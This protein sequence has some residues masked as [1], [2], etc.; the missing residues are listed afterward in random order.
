MLRKAALQ[1]TLRPIL[2]FVPAANSRK[3]CAERSSQA[4]N[5]SPDRKK[6]VDTMPVPC[7]YVGERSTLT[8]QRQSEP[9]C[10]KPALG[11][12]RIHGMAPSVR[13]PPRQYL[14][15]SIWSE[16]RSE[17]CRGDR[18][19]DAAKSH[20]HTHQQVTGRYTCFTNT[21]HQLSQQRKVLTY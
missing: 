21:C 16:I 11:P 13:G 2:Q 14:T 9:C 1:A 20:H 10:I 12:W 3:P 7:Y 17:T 8:T 6:H 19:I 5:L 4:K 15:R 18:M